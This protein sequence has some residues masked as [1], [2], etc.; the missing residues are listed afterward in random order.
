MDAVP[1]EKD[2]QGL[3]SLIRKNLEGRLSSGSF[4]EWVSPC[5]ALRCE[6]NTLSIQVPNASTKL[7]IEQQLAEEFNDALVQEDLAHLNLVFQISGSL[8]VQTAQPNTTPVVVENSQI[9]FPSLF[10]RYTL[11]RFVVG[12][13]SQLAFA[14]AN[15]VVEHFGKSSSSFN[16]NPLFIYGSSGLGKTHLM[17]GVGQA[18]RDKNPSAKLHYLKVDGFFHEVTAAISK[19]N[20]EPLRK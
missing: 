19:R 20:T 5:I 9:S 8:Q 10:A 18:I 6:G 11:D 1:M 12:P 7:W 13:S 14:A 15:S 3:W 2:A 17:V 16:M 4:Q